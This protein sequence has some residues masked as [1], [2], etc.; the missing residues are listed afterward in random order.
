MTQF[1]TRI[2]D[3]LAGAIDALVSAG[4]VESRS[5]AVRIGL[6]QL[7]DR[8]RRRQIGESIAAGYRGLPQSDAELA[9]LDEATRA[10]VA[11]EPW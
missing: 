4:V 8:H 1:V 2:D 11:E 7:V 6:A 10:L 3:E 5:D 9:G